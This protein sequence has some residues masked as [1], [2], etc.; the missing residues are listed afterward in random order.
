VAAGY[1]RDEAKFLI[2]KGIAGEGGDFDYGKKIAQEKNKILNKTDLEHL[3]DAEKAQQKYLEVIKSTDEKQFTA[4]ERA[5]ARAEVSKYSEMAADLKARGNSVS[6]KDRAT[7]IQDT[8]GPSKQA[9]NGLIDDEVNMR[10]MLQHETLSMQGNT[11]NATNNIIKQAKY[12]GM[13]DDEVADL[14]NMAIKSQGIDTSKTNINGNEKAAEVMRS[15][16]KNLTASIENPNRTS[17]LDIYKKAKEASLR[18]LL[19]EKQV[20][21]RQRA[22]GITKFDDIVDNMGKFERRAYDT[23]LAERNS[24]Q[25]ALDG[26]K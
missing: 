5:E 2:R 7:T 18:V 26:L 17:S 16:V 10:A 24:L 14:I 1:K 12:A 22:D 25:K 9:L 13:K 19:F 11:A 21:Y 23:M 20:E 8:Y 15:M 3:D 4:L 6:G